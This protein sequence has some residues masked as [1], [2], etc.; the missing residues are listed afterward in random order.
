MGIR[1]AIGATSSD[2]I[3]LIVGQAVGLAAIGVMIGVAGALA[4]T[5]VIRALLFDTDPL[6][7]LTFAAS[8]AMLLLI[9]ALSSYL[10]ARRALRTDPTIAMRAE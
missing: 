10:P 6:D 4:L 5:R 1:I 3:R 9:A 7:G 2:M 8:A